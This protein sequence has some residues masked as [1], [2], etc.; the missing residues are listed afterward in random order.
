MKTAILST[1]SELL[2]GTIA[3]TNAQWMAARLFEM[4]AP[5]EQ[6]LT[7]GDSIHDVAAALSALWARANL[8]VCTG[9]LGPTTD[10][11][12][13]A[14]VARALGVSLVRNPVAQQQV[15]QRFAARA[16]DMPEINL[17]QADLP[18]GAEI[19]ENRTGTAPGFMVSKND[20]V[21]LF[22]PGVPAEM[23]EMFQRHV[24][25]LVRQK[26]TPRTSKMVRT[27][28]IGESKLQE[29]ILPLEQLFPE[30]TF[31]YRAAFPTVTTT[32]W[33]ENAQT[34]S[35][36]HSELHALLETHAFTTDDKTLAQVLADALTERHLTIASAESCTGG[37]IGHELTQIHGSSAFYLG[38]VIAYDNAVKT[39]LLNVSPELL[40]EH[41]AVSES[42]V[43]QMARGVQQKL[44]A[45]IGV[46]TSGIAGP[47]GGSTE[48]PVGT[49]H[50]AVAVAE[51]IFHKKCLF[52]GYS[53][54]KVKTASTWT[55]MNLVH[56]QL[57][58]KQ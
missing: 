11:I 14:A 36:A 15:E 41:G 40:S 48:K 27:F 9:G 28:G 46:A 35:R 33:G 6:I 30:L 4:S 43:C 20:R 55:A 2:R 42:V 37:Q 26:A 5:P 23:T 31:S 7:V 45:D 52:K 19:L 18:H 51:R 32:I 25:P 58:E 10:D 3:D 1:G 24:V 12:T 34:V 54:T 16:F 53:R 47:G 56:Q 57:L 50:I 13:A 17:K 8:V 38:G 49:V 22:L 44:G 29:R 21:A 39:S